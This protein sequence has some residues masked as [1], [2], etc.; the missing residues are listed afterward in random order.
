MV[1][2]TYNVLG[3]V[4][5]ARERPPLEQVEVVGR[6]VVILVGVWRVDPRRQTSRAHSAREVEG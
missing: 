5:H 1:R 6:R 3:G 4:H 2:G